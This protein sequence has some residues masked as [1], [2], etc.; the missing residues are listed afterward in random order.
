MA[1]Q[2][3][4]IAITYWQPQS[5]RAKKPR[6]EIPDDGT[7]I[8]RIIG[9]I[10]LSREHKDEFT[11]ELWPHFYSDLD[12]LNLDPKEVDDGDSIEYDFNGERK[13]ITF[14]QFGNM[15]SDY[16]NSKK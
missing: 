9:N 6:K 5:K 14:E 4:N 2:I 15:V 12:G 1:Q 7:A 8:S 16:R 11:I 13:L 10:A 3:A